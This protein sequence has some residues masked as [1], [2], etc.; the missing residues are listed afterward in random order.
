LAV[1]P[2]AEWVARVKVSVRQRMSMSGWWSAASAASATRSTTAIAAGKLD[3]SAVRVIP[4]GPPLHPS[5][6]A[7]AESIAA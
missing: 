6:F 2:P 5:S 4:S 3:S 1:T 7:S